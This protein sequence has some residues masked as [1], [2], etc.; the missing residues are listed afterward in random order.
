MSRILLEHEAKTLLVEAGLPVLPFRFAATEQ[1]VL[2]AAGELGYPVSLK[3]VSRDVPHKSDAGGVMLGMENEIALR[4]AY[5][6]ILENVAQ[7]VPNARLEGMI[8]SP[9]A[10]CLQEIIVGAVKDAQFGH[11]VMAGLG[12]IFVE[13]LKDVAFEL[14]PVTEAQAGFMLAS[15]KGFLLL[16][17]TRGRPGVNLKALA[18]LIAAVSRFAVA[19]DVEELDLNPV[20]CDNKGVAIVDAR[21]KFSGR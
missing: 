7:H 13:A 14:A 17:G 3:I 5:Y 4:Q 8:L 20:F 21:I 11:V 15:L 1:E 2:T 12:G 18:G 10:R 9:M 19:Q 16:E 6:R